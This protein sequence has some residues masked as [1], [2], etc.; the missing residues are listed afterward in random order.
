[1]IGTGSR[2]LETLISLPRCVLNWIDTMFDAAVRGPSS[3]ASAAYGLLENAVT[4]VV[5]PLPHAFSV[6]LHSVPGGN[7]K[8]AAGLPIV[9][10]ATKASRSRSSGVSSI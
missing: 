2:R 3:G 5:M 1:M 6:F 8:E 7:S 4:T 10:A 9:A